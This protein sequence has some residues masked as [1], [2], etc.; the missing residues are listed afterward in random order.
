[1]LKLEFTNIE[2]QRDVMLGCILDRKRLK[3]LL[4]SLWHDESLAKKE[5]KVMRR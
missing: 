5:Q 3:S 2:R 4:D 1:M